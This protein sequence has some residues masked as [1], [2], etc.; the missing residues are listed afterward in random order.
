M[1]RTRTFPWYHL[2]LPPQRT[3]SQ[4]RTGPSAL[5]GAPVFA[6]CVGFGKAAQKGIRPPLSHCLAPTGSSL[7]DGLRKPTWFLHRVDH[8]GCT[9]TLL[10]IKV[11][12]FFRFFR[13]TAQ[14][15]AYTNKNSKRRCFRGISF[16]NYRIRHGQAAAGSDCRPES[17][18][19]AG[20]SQT[21]SRPVE[22]HR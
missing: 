12:S 10:G 8:Y 3:A 21:T 11:N 1:Q 20:K 5:P 16:S 2:N 17:A 9:L 22:N 15:I 7:R 19:G 4:A 13:L 6:Y 18:T 14:N